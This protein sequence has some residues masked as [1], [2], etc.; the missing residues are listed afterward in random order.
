MNLKETIRRVLNEGLKERMIQF[1]DE[2]GV[3]SAVDFF[4]GWKIIE[5]TIGDENVTTKMKI[6]F[7][8]EL[9]KEQGGISVFD[10]NEDPIYFGRDGNEYQEIYYFGLRSVTIQ[11]WDRENNYTDL[12]E[13]IVSYENLNDGQID[14][15]FYMLMEHNRRGLRL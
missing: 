3:K 2:Y 9:T 12:G 6:N 10:L 1:I 5:D 7:I 15:I 11:M 14:D 8:K 4:G 13:F